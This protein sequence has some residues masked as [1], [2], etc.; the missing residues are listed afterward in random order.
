MRARG[1]PLLLFLSLTLDAPPVVALAPQNQPHSATLTGSVV[2]ASGAAI[3]GAEV[4]A[5]GRVALTD[6][7]GRF[8]LP[9]DREQLTIRVRAP[10]FADQ[11]V[12]ANS[13]RP[14]RI[15]LH[16]AGVAETVT[17]TASRSTHRFADTAT[18]TTVI[19]SP[20]LLTSAALTADDALRTVPGFSLFR[21]SSSRAANP[22]TQGASL[23]G[24]AASGASRA[25]V[26]A[27]G[28]PLNDPFGGWVYW[29]RVPQAAIERIEVVRGGGSAG[30]YG[31]QAVAGAIQLFTIDPAPS[32][33]RLSVEGGNRGSGRASGY[34]GWG[35]SG[36]SSFVAGERFVY[37]GH[38]I[39][40][41]DERG[42]VDTPAGARS[43]SALVDVAHAGRRGSAGV[44]AGWLDED[45]NNGTPLQRNDTN[46]RS[47]SGRGQL[48]TS[49]GAWMVTASAGAT[50]Y[51]QSFSSVVAGR[52]AEILT[53][54][55]KVESDHLDVAAQ[56]SGL[57]RG[58]AL[59]AGG[60]V[61][62]ISGA[63]A[64]TAPLEEPRG[65]TERDAAGYVQL[66][67]QA[68][69]RLTFTAGS[70]AGWW[71]TGADA[72]DAGDDQRWFFAMPRASMAWAASP[73]LQ[74]TASWASGGRTPT[75]N[76]LYRD[77]QVGNA[78][79]A[80]NAELRPETTGTFEAGVLLR[81]AT[82]S[83][84]VTAFWTEL[85]HAVTNVTQSVSGSRIQR[86]RDNAGTIRA[87]GIEAETE[88]RPA[89]WTSLLVTL[90]AF[91]SKFTS[92]EEPGLAGRRVSQVPR[93]QSSASLRMT[94]GRAVATIDWRGM[95]SQYD[96]DRNLFLL[97]RAHV[98][99]LYAGAS[100]PRLQ[101]FVAIE[102]VFDVEV[103]VGRTP[104]RTIGTPRTARV[105]LRVFMR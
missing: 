9:V 70:R 27:D 55:Q 105:G 8:S 83:A 99:D 34:G 94:P 28:V 93:W 102:N 17:V 20:A 74:V 98:V 96:D 95:G 30:L 103:D 45:R 7:A 19:S 68:T 15:T 89:G 6:A 91:D 44:R 24:L 48:N 58:H 50:D 49:A 85:D 10:G 16:T 11:V 3:R 47:I 18:A 51:D 57:W 79:T 87:R 97:R 32:H 40:A 29:N 22:T 65:G 53:G 75:L 88:W 12:V 64:E 69:D 62:E 60:E 100:F 35:T 31:H 72:G 104:V 26:L 38:P 1:A 90:A 61:R 86:Q 84:R 56:W 23:R 78:F 21:R 76:E 101:P 63:S 25:L 14:A 67:V 52:T 81:R 36:W 46:V 4:T 42:P 13:S 80:A 33:A 82:A 2:D 77:F 66:R 41:E 54:R 43:W 5:E 39:V 37:D 92:S 71:Q 59:V 73:S